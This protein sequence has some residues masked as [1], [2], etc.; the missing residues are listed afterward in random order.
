LPRS[1]LASWASSR[2]QT[3]FADWACATESAVSAASPPAT[4]VQGRDCLICAYFSLKTLV[5]RAFVVSAL[6]RP[7]NAGSTVRLKR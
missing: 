1:R 4:K 6:V 7:R 2:W 5:V 3:G